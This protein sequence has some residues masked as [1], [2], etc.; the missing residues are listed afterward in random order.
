[1]EALT[2]LRKNVQSS[3]LVIGMREVRKLLKQDKLSRIFVASNRPE[4]SMRDM[5]QSCDAVNC[6]LVA[7]SIPNDELGV[8]CKKPFSIVAVGVLR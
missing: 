3:K 4:S 2:E 1:M 7:L 5:R 8:M 6:E